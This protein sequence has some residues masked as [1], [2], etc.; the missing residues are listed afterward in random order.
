[1]DTQ[2]RNLLVDSF[3]INTRSTSIIGYM[4][5]RVYTMSY[6]LFMGNIT[7]E[8]YLSYADEQL[9]NCRLFGVLRLHLPL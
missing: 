1:M 3:T 2:L 4:R 7:E 9:Q 6:L 8:A 5:S